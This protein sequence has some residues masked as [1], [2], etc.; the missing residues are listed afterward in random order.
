MVRERATNS[1]IQ[2]STELAPDVDLVTGDERRV[3]QIV[4]KALFSSESTPVAPASSATTPITLANMPLAGCCLAAIMPW[5]AVA[6]CWPTRP[7]ICS[8]ILP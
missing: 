4:F 3:R 6:L 5:I 1:G 8:T 7:L 2:L